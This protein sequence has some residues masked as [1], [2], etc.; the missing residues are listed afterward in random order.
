MPRVEFEPNDPSVRADEDG[1]CL[2]PHDHRDRLGTCYIEIISSYSGRVNERYRYDGGHRIKFYI[3][4][5]FL[6]YKTINS[7]S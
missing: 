7:A 2:R 6:L 3:F 1:S 5:G 4:H